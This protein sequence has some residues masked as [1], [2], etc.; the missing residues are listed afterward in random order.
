MSDDAVEKIIPTRRDGT[1]KVFWFDPDWPGHILR[2]HDD[3]TVRSICFNHH[4]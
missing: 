3:G 4:G 2:R 1:F